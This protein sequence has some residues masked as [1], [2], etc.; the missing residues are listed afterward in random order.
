MLGGVEI[1]PV[2]CSRFFSRPRL[3]HRFVPSYLTVATTASPMIRDAA[4]SL[5]TVLLDALRHRPI[6]LTSSSPKPSTRP[7]RLGSERAYFT[8]ICHYRRMPKTCAQPPAG[9]ELA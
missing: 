2:R 9:V 6:R 1:V 7:A 3:S 8:H 5:R 4:A